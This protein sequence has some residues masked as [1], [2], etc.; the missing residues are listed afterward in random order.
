V[1]FLTDEPD[2]V[3]VVAE[4]PVATAITMIASD[5][6]SNLFTIYPPLSLTHCQMAQLAPTLQRAVPLVLVGIILLL[7]N[8]YVK[9]DYITTL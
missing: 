4:Q 8:C 7:I 6:I 3:L 2:S 5:N 1:P 9:R